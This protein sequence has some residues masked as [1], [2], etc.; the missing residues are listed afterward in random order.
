MRS[1]MEDPGAVGAATGVD[2]HRN[3][4]SGHFVDSAERRERQARVLAARHCLA[5]PY[6]RTVVD[7][8]LADARSEGGAA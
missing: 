8:H 4:G 5:L 7:I 1:K 2:T 6:A 3:E